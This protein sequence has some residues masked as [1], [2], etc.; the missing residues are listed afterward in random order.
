MGILLGDLSKPIKEQDIPYFQRLL[1]LI[2][3]HQGKAE[4]YRKEL[5]ELDETR[6][7]I[8]YLK[9]KAVNDVAQHVLLETEATT[10]R[11]LTQH[12]LIYHSACQKLFEYA[13]RDFIITKYRV[14]EK[15]IDEWHVDLEHKLLYRKVKT[16]DS[17]TLDEVQE[18]TADIS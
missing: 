8:E 14:H 17:L 3:L 10:Q 4:H 7:L 2:A 12:A 16:T 9:R 11:Q 5:D 13:L 18:M 15:Q 6:Y 1:Q